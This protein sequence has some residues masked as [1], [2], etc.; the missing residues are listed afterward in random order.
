M[1]LLLDT[2]I[3]V[4]WLADD[5]RL[6]RQADRLISDPHNEVFVSAASV[7]E[8]S[9]KAALGRITADPAAIEA[10]LAPSGFV[11]LPIT[12]KHAVQVAR[13]PLYHH[14]PFDRI[15]IAQSLVEPMR[16]LTHDDALA[17]YGE[18]VISV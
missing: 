13:L 12:A 2:H 8:I 11:E 17:R 9:I 14:D 18:L 3:V 15:L 7:W 16:L 10:A 4:W 5:K 6:S 1:R